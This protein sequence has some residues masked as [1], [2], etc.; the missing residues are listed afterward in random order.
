MA[1]EEFNKR[2]GIDDLFRE[3]LADHKISPGN[4]TWHRIRRRQWGRSYRSAYLLIAL[5]LLGAA[6]ITGYYT[7]PGETGMDRS[8]EQAIQRNDE[9]HTSD[10]FQEDAIPAKP[11]V[12]EQAPSPAK[13]AKSLTDDQHSAPTTVAEQADA[14]VGKPAFAE[15]NAGFEKPETSTSRFTKTREDRDA[16]WRFKMK[17]LQMDVESGLQSP[18]LLQQRTIEKFRLSFRDDYARKA[19]AL[20]SANFTPGIT[21]YRSKPQKNFYSIDLTASHE[22]SERLS[23]DLGAGIYHEKDNGR[24][25]FNYQTYDSVGYYMNVT[26]F[27]YDPQQD[28]VILNMKSE[29]VYDSVEH[30]SVSNTA[31]TYSYFQLPLGFTYRLF[32]FSRFSFSFRSGAIFMLLMSKD[33]PEAN[34]SMSDAQLIDVSDETPIRMNTAWKYYTSLQ[35]SYQMSNNLFLTLEPVYQQYFGKLYRKETFSGAKHPYSI[36]FRTGVMFKF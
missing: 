5:V 4:A 23:I 35:I 8:N 28:T 20:L 7:L 24:Y 15:N 19:N 13:P 26:S 32:D 1:T 29:S 34:L 12:K 22:L 18:E 6:G 17:L 27:Y 33:I 2:E 10:A 31:N 16:Y 36:G 11:E 30:I 9:G 21:Y 14:T 3:A 25:R